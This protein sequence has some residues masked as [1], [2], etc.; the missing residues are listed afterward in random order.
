MDNH[1][2]DRIT[3]HGVTIRVVLQELPVFKMN[4]SINPRFQENFGAHVPRLAVIPAFTQ[5]TL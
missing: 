5:I 4:N 2:I 1:I 3:V